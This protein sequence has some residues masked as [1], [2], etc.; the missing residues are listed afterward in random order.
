MTQLDIR[1]SEQPSKMPTELP[2]RARITYYTYLTCFTIP[3]RNL[4][5]KIPDPAFNFPAGPG[6]SFTSLL[7]QITAITQLSCTL[8]I[9]CCV[10]VL[11][12][13]RAYYNMWLHPSAFK[14]EVQ[15]IHRFS[16]MWLSWAV[17]FF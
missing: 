9:Q 13:I 10:I 4:F 8:Y 12:L 17:A 14:H 7:Q 2:Q 16:L 6:F 15:E 5:S 3:I 11:V 1:G